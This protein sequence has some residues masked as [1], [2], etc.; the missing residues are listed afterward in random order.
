MAIEEPKYSVIEKTEPFEVR[1]YA[2]MILAEVKW[3]VT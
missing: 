3:T 2:P 1:Q